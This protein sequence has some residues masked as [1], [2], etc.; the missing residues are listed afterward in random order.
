MT[1]GARARISRG[2]LR[3]NLEI[4][5]SRSADA[6]IMAMVKANAYG[7]GLVPVAAAL[8]DVDSLAV[9]RLAEAR[10]LREA[11]I[12][13]RVVVLGGMFCED[14]IAE[15][16][17]LDIEPVVHDERQFRWL[18]DARIRLPALWLKI[19]TGMRRLGFEP[20]VADGFIA[21]LAEVTDRPG[22]MTQFSSA[23]EPQDPATLE[24]L[25]S[26]LA[27][28]DGFDGELSVANSPVVFG[29]DSARAALLAG[30]APRR[31]WVRPGIALYGIAPF[32]DRDG[33]DFELRPVMQFEA[34]LISV[35]PIRAGARVG[36]G[37]AWQAQHDTTL[38]I[39]AAGYGDGYSRFIPSGTPILL[40]GRRVF[41]AGRISM[42]LTAVDLGPAASDCA[43]DRAVLWGNGLP[44]E[45]VARHAGTIPYQLVAGLTH[46]EEPVFED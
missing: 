2:A 33:A 30:L 16:R 40:N 42:D 17:A 5:R 4:I 3:H 31:L 25:Q 43:G 11:G 41:V 19:D 46:R 9:A 13:G 28:A 38:G 36:Y 29:E 1:F 20:A 15:F 37:G 23:D 44:V 14:E 10:A 32:G 12:D 21:R 39:I 45:E 35:K 22:L 18:K 34:T 8:R 6:R 7:H 27:L 24:Q 26:F